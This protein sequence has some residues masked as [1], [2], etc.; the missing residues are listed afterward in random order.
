MIVFLLGFLGYF[1]SLT[2]YFNRL[3]LLIYFLVLFLILEFWNFKVLMEE[4]CLCLHIQYLQFRISVFHRG[5]ASGIYRT[6]LWWVVLYLPFIYQSE[7]LRCGFG[8][9]SYIFVLVAWNGWSMILWSE[10]W[11]LEM[12]F[13]FFFFVRHWYHIYLPNFDF[14]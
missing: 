6:L 11:F 2:V 9:L 1:I 10:Y 3:Y 14:D 4:L 7:R 12:I 8:S 13:F 5:S